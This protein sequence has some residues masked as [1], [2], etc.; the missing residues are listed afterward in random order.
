MPHHTKT[1][2]G[3]EYGKIFAVFAI[4][5]GTTTHFRAKHNFKLGGAFALKLTVWHW[6]SCPKIHA[7]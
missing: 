5:M 1:L 4:L 7:C 2:F 6:I 3:L